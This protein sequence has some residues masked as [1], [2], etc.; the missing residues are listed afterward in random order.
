MPAPLT[1][2]RLIIGH[3]AM[4]RGCCCGDISRGKPEAPVEWLK[5]EWRALGLLKTVQLTISGCL[6]PCDLSNVV[7]V[8][9]S[10]GSTWLGNIRDLRQYQT[11]VDWASASKEAG[12]LLSL[13]EELSDCRFNPYRSETHD[14]QAGAPSPSGRADNCRFIETSREHRRDR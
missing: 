6:G 5:N 14:L 1:T 13:P 7:T 9:D 11:L 12:Y 2:K 8:S 4:C 10:S 3:V